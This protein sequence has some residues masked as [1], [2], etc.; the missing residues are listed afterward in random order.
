MVP[1]EVHRVRDLAFGVAGR[2]AV[3]DEG[4]II[5]LGTPDEVKRSPH[6]V[7]QKFLQADFNLKSTQ[8]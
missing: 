6:A 4:Q 7:I 1:Q 8:P 2:I 5:A 3:L